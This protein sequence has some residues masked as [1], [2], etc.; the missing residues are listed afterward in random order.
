MP[1]DVGHR[2]LRY[3]EEGRLQFERESSVCSYR[4]THH[5]DA[6]RSQARIGIELKGLEEP[7]IVQQGRPE[8]ADDPADLRRDPLG[9]GVGRRQRPP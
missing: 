1:R 3:A 4:L 9:Q 8:I 6:R 2:L 7:Q 5:L